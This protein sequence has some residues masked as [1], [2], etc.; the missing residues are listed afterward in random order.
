MCFHVKK[1]D[2]FVKTGAAACTALTRF[3]MRLPI[4]GTVLYTISS[5]SMGALFQRTGNQVINTP[6]NG[7]KRYYLS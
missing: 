7:Y 3:I 4:A 1:K 2:P 5:Q 6:F